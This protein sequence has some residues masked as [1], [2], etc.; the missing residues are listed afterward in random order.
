VTGVEE[1]QPR[2]LL[3]IPL[4]P[5]GRGLEEFQV[6]RTCVEGWKNI[7]KEIVGPI[8]FDTTLSNTVVMLGMWN[9]CFFG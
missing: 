5:G 4:A 6:I 7:Q 3:G 1:G 8:V 9:C 2:Q